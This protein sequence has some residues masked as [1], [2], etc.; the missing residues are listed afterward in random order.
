MRSTCLIIKSIHQVYLFQIGLAILI[1]FTTLNSSGEDNR[2]NTHLP[3]ASIYLL[4]P[5]SG[6]PIRLT[7]LPIPHTSFLHQH[8][9]FHILQLYYPVPYSYLLI[10]L[11][12]LPI[13][14]RTYFSSYV[15]YTFQNPKFLFSHP[16]FPFTQ[17]YLSSA[18][19]IYLSIFGWA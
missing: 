16:I 8:F 5:S 15:S 19:N 13:L 4:T 18:I 10:L 9:Y 14:H 12:Y 6:L 17:K 11:N 1:V 7:D 3:I 2:N